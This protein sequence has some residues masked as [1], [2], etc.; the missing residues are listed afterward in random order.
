MTDISVNFSG[1]KL[2]N[3]L[4]AAAR[5][6]TANVD[7]IQRL[8]DSG[9][10]AIITKTGFTKKEYEKWVGRRDIFPYKPVYKYQSLEDGKLLS[11]PTLADMPI[12][13]M[14]R[15]LE[16]I[17]RFNIPVIGSIMGLSPEGYAE[18]ARILSNA[19]ADAIEIDLCCT[20]PEFTTTY[21][22]A[23][24][25]V[26]FY[27]KKYA[28]LVDVVKGVVSIPVGVKS[29][30]SLYLYGNIIEGL[31]RSKLKNILPDFITL[32]GQLDFNP[33]V[34]LGTLKPVIPHIPSFGW[35]G[36]LSGLTYSALATF[37]ST[38][39]TTNP[40]LSASGGIRDLESVVNAM[41]MGATTVQIL[42]AV[43]DKG[44]GIIKNI[45]DSLQAFLESKGIPRIADI[46]GYASSEYIPSLV[47]GKFMLER[48]TLFGKIFAEVS[49]DTCTGCGICRNVCTEGAISLKNRKAVIDKN[50][51]RACNLCV[52]KCSPKAIALKNIEELFRLIDK[53]K[54][55]EGVRS[56]RKFLDKGKITWLDRLCMM[57]NL[58]QWGLA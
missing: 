55:T 26:N 54:N 4:I 39:G 13:D 22:Y 36:T 32:V 2:R 25:N 40:Y 37:S 14:A 21:K 44:P 41:A 19:G 24:Q 9:I 6:I 33:G 29:T 20:I 27:P 52:L 7:N 1:L 56:F 57:R 5:P 43:L 17:K 16:K 30:V 45:L 12:S 34:D 31:I 53:Y 46:I 3:P 11:L 49:E 23:G 51:C 8:V 42:T 58:K 10:G 35:Q 15:R 48:D 50:L 18:S 47:L 38:L 28:H